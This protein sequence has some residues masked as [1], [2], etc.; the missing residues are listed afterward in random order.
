MRVAPSFYLPTAPL[1][2]AALLPTLF[3]I[4]PLTKRN[5]ANCFKSAPN[6][7]EPLETALYRPILVMPAGLPLMA[8]PADARECISSLNLGHLA[9]QREV[10]FYGLPAPLPVASAGCH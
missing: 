6:L 4:S 1:W 8:L 7:S 2:R 9:H 10:V 5:A 3:G